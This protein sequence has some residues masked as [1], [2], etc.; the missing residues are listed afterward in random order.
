MIQAFNNSYGTKNALAADAPP[1]S[2]S[3]QRPAPWRGSYEVSG[4]R[5]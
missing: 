3:L 5:T 2:A 4:V 1:V